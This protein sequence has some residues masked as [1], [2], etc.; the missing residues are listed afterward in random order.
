VDAIEVKCDYFGGSDGSGGC[1]V[2]NVDL[3]KNT[4]NDKFLFS[5]TQEQKENTTRIWFQRS[6]RVAHLPHNLVEE[7]PKLILLRIFFSV[8]P[9]VKNNL[10]GPQFS[11]IEWLVLVENKIKF[12]EDQAFQHLLNV[13][14]INLEGNEI[15]SLA[16]GLFEHNRKLEEV[17]L[18]RNNIKMI[19]PEVFQNLNQLRWVDLVLNDLKRNPCV[20]KI[21]ACSNCDTEIYH[22]ELNRELQD[23]YDNHKK[24][25]DWLDEGEN[26]FIIYLFIYLFIQI[27]YIQYAKKLLDQAI[28]GLIF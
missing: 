10:L 4:I 13:T 26:K 24:S 9:I 28:F 25:L 27:V 15:H 17:D 11:W 19:A 18:S 23:C 22:T 21:I 1:K 2:R 8:I 20:N 7:M 14:I 5:G 12:I 6:G 3:S 16:A